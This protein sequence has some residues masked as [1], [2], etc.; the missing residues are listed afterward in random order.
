[1]KSK[2]ILPIKSFRKSYAHYY[3]VCVLF[4][5]FWLGKQNANLDTRGDLDFMQGA[6][7]EFFFFSVKARMQKQFSTTEAIIHFS[8]LN[9]CQKYA[10]SARDDYQSKLVVGPSYREF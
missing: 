3:D 4:N 7:G 9:T 8:L 10:L 1:M 2:K 5:I 6:C